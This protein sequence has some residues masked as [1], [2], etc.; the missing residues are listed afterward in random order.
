MGNR[1]RTIWALSLASAILLIGMQGYWLYNQYQ[2]VVNTYAQDMSGKILDA[3][4]KE[5]KIR[6][7]NKSQMPLFINND[8]GLDSIYQGPS[9]NNI[10]LHRF[11]GYKDEIKTIYLFDSRASE[12]K[13]EMKMSN[14]T[15]KFVHPDSVD[16]VRDLISDSLKLDMKN[17]S[18]NPEFFRR[19]LQMSEFE[20]DS[21]AYTEHSVMYF[22]VNPNISKEYISKGLEQVMINDRV[23]FCMEILDSILITDIPGIEYKNT[24]MDNKDSIM[25]SSWHL[26]GSLFSP[27]IKVLYVYSILESKGVEIDAAIP[28]PTLLKSMAVQL[29]LSLSL[30][31][32]LTG[33]LIL[34]IKTILKQKKI[35]ELREGFVNAMVHELKRP[36]QTLKTFIS[37]LGNKEMRSDESITEQVIQDSMFE[38]D[39]LSVYLKKLK[40]M[41]CADND[42]TSLQISRFNLRELIEK[43]VRL[44][45]S[46]TT[47]DINIT[48]FYS[49]D[50]LWVEA[51]AVH[52]ANVLNNLIENAIKYSGEH[53]DI[54]IKVSLKGRELWLT[55][56][57]NG[58]G[59]PFSEKDKVFAKFYRGSN[60][61][62]KNI[63]GIGLGLSYVKLI[64]EAHKGKVS[65]LSDVGK[66]TSVTFYLPQ[67]K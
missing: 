40:D 22:S 61:P 56:S 34:Q 3:G 46:S 27:H 63:P 36:V 1:I 52:I 45:K 65:L 15:M 53:V 26:S 38:L 66:G 31:L 16:R 33:C 49:S 21:S 58:I 11:S 67:S 43:I 18:E 12:S 8:F 50:L 44:A 6:N 29:L 20:Q 14:I 37:F 51:D 39:N 9:G 2:Y 60:I 19:S 48:M 17:L 30:I 13:L 23:P 24:S 5:L 10:A 35:N 32:L 7:S 4:E 55:V 42:V 62:D 54:E 41:I 28:S 47:K 59:I 25:T 64:I 57:D